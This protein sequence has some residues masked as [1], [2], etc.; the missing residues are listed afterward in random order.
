MRS[1]MW[2]AVSLRLHNEDANDFERRRSVLHEDVSGVVDLLES[3]YIVAPG[4]NS[5]GTTGGSTRS[6]R[7]QQQLP[8]PT[9]QKL[10]RGEAG[11]ARGLRT[12]DEA[13]RCRKLAGPG[14]MPMVAHSTPNTRMCV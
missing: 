2:S 4:K 9:Q 14:L 8:S 13:R 10:E 11:R 5:S 6:V 3:V 12:M 7:Q 1:L